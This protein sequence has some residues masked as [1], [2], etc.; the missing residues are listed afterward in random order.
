MRDSLGPSGCPSSRLP[1]RPDL[2]S[3]TIRSSVA[4]RRGSDKLLSDLPLLLTWRLSP[5]LFEP[6][7]GIVT[8]VWQ[9]R[10]NEL[11]GWVMTIHARADVSINRS[12]LSESPHC[13]WT[14][15]SAGPRGCQNKVFALDRSTVGFAIQLII[16]S[17]I[18]FSVPVE[19]YSSL[20]C[21]LLV[22]GGGRDSQP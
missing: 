1:A 19:F 21:V 14:S 8:V 9:R 17:A 20:G 13:R 15:C 7:P 16:S 10:T 5:T 6:A 18:F 11:D 12:L 2:D 4:S 22:N 3:V